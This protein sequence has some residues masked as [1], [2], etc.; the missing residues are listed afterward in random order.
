MSMLL[1]PGGIGHFAPGENGPFCPALTQA[2]AE[3]ASVVNNDDTIS[4][5]F[6]RLLDKAD[7]GLENVVYLSFKLRNKTDNEMPLYSLDAVETI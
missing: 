1:E 4:L 3:E 7:Y 5:K 6:E 2:Y